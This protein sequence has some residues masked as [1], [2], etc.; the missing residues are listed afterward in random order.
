MIDLDAIVG[1]VK[2]RPA[3]W[4][5]VD[6]RNVGLSE[7][8]AWSA[9]KTNTGAEDEDLVRTGHTDTHWRFY[10]LP[11]SDPPATPDYAVR[12]KADYIAF[13]RPVVAADHSGVLREITASGSW[14][15]GEWERFETYLS[16]SLRAR[17]SKPWRRYGM[18]G[19]YLRQ[20][21]LESQKELDLDAIIAR[22]VPQLDLDDLIARAARPR[23][24]PPPPYRRRTPSRASIYR[25]RLSPPEHRALLCLVVAGIELAGQPLTRAVCRCL[26]GGHQQTKVQRQRIMKEARD[27]GV[28][29]MRRIEGTSDM[30][31]MLDARLLGPLRKAADEAI[32]SPPCVSTRYRPLEE[33][34]V[35]LAEALSPPGLVQRQYHGES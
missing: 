6:R 10:V 26:G 30:D 15:P 19:Y 27:R 33:H 20:L 22:V 9:A 28:L 25:L 34:L 31:V 4:A 5:E 2:G 16:P 24:D 8:V 14:Q 3:F 17:L 11:L 1:K 13:M 29:D 32:D 12:L 35:A 7:E 23:P 18:A 21:V